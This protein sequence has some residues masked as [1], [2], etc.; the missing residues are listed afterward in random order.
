MKGLFRNAVL[1]SINVAL[2]AVAAHARQLAVVVDKSNSQSAISS[3]DLARILLADTRKWADGRT[4]F[5]VMSDHSSNDVQQVLQKILR[6]S[7][8]K[9]RGLLAAHKDSFVLVNSDEELLKRVA[10]MPGAIGLVDVYSITSAVNV[11]RVDSKLPLES[12]YPLR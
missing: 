11:L 6:V 9:A 1:L 10:S 5:L 2:C 12:G 8:D 7:E 3:G 4:I